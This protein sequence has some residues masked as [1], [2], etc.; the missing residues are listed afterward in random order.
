MLNASRQ[1][2]AAIGIALLGALVAGRSGFESG[3]R[4]AT[5]VARGAY[6]VTAAIGFAIPAPQEED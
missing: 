6:V 2:G 1:V 4:A 5:P 3:F